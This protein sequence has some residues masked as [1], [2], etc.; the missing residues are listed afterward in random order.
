MFGEMYVSYITRLQNTIAVQSNSFLLTV[1]E[2]FLRSQVILNRLEL[3]RR[4]PLI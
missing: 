2:K 4:Q 3:G 1:V